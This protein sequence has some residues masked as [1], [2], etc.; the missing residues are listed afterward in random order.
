MCL[1]AKRAGNW[2]AN[3]ERVPT[4]ERKRTEKK[5]QANNLNA[6]VRS[7][8]PLFF[9]DKT[10][11]AFPTQSMGSPQAAGPNLGNR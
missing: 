9:P 4:T 10:V 1:E 5:F 6:W 8:M 11:P 3:E 7:R 2:R